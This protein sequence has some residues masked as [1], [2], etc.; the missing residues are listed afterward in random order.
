MG[1]VLSFMASSEPAPGPRRETQWLDDAPIVLAHEAPVRI[2]PLTIEPAMR[3][4]IHD[5]GQEAFL[6]PR[7]MQALV[8]LVRADGRILSRDDMMAQCWSGRVVGEDALNRVVARLR[9]LS[10][11]L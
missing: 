1:R 4:V 7:V 6:E 2:G 3:R 8:A 5:N 11:G 9:R 10:E